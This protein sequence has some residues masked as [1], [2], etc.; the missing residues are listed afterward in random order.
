MDKEPPSGV[1]ELLHG[2]GP[3]P[4]Y[5]NDTPEVFLQA[6]VLCTQI[7]EAHTFLYPRNNVPH[8]LHH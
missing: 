7:P 5:G 8:S 2:P 4:M 6:P 1:Q 3:D